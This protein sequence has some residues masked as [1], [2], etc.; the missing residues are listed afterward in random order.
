LLARLGPAP[1]RIFEAQLD[2]ASSDNSTEPQNEVIAQRKAR[3]AIALL[4]LGRPEKVWSLFKQARDERVRSYLIN[5]SKPL[6]V[7]PQ[8]VIQ[9]WAVETEVSKRC[10]LLLLLGEFPAEAWLE[11]Q[12]QR[13][14]EQLFKIFEKDSDPGLHAAAYWLLRKWKCNDR[15]KAA[16]EHLRTN[17]AERRAGRNGQR[18]WYINRQSQTF[19]IV[20]ARG[21]FTMGSPEREPERD[22]NETQHQRM[23]GRRYAMAANPVTKGQ[24]QTFLNDRPNV[25]KE[26]I[27]KEILEKIVRTDDSPQIGM[28]WYEAADYCNWLSE[29]EG[30][31]EDQWCYVPNEEGKFA[32]GMRAKDKYLNLTG[33]R[34]PTEAE[35][36]FACRAGTRTRFY[37]GQDDALLAKYAWYRANSSEGISPVA[38]L[39]PNDFGL[40]DML[41]NVWQ[42]CEC[43]ALAYPESSQVAAVDSGSSGKVTNDLRA[44]LRGGA[45]NNLTGH[46]RAAY[47]ARYSPDMR[48][49]SFGFRPAQTV[50]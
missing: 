35:W 27:K 19:V 26:Q 40:F 6:G 20:D 2:L 5:W 10:A 1:L 23:I 32:A 31:S 15:L 49:P 33:Y 48:Q 14:I 22:D 34:L 25:A 45:Y 24:F 3:A 21:P 50:N 30:I 43:P 8:V 41:G 38:R 39:K 17:E 18:R 4:Q 7:D 11:E 13:L 47:R 37:F 28:T 9:H 29:K 46:V 16:I 44:A 42:W 12:R 36:E